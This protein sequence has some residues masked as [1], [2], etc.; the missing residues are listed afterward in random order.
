MAVLYMKMKL[1]IKNLII[2]VLSIVFIFGFVRQDR[3]MKRIEKEKEAKQIQLDELI[4]KNKRLQEENDKAQSDEYLEQ[5]ARER[6][7]MIKKG[8]ISTE[9]KKIESN[10]EN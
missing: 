6:L 9:N 7:N 10:S 2:I 5:L 8:E 1:N 3:A 4:E